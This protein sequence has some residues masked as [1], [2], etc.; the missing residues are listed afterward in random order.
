MNIYEEEN[1]V[2]SNNNS[3]ISSIVLGIIGGIFMGI[4]YI[5]IGLLGGKSR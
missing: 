3:E 5:F 2:V 4:F 1:E